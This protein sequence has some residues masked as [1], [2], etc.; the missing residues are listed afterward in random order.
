MVYAG[1]TGIKSI[2]VSPNSYSKLNIQVGDA[3]F[4]QGVRGL[5]RFYWH[6]TF[7][8][9]I[10]KKRGVRMFVI[11]AGRTVVKLILLSSKFTLTQ[12]RSNV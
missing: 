6:Q 1:R 10:V 3:Y 7:T 4:T 8:L 9:K 5:N 12:C 2:F 11:F